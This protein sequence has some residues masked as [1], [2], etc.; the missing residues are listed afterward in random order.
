M[1]ENRCLDEVILKQD[2]CHL[3]DVS[4]KLLEQI[5]LHDG[6]HPRKAVIG[7]NYPLLYLAQRRRGR[8]HFLNDDGDTRL[9][10]DFR[11]QEFRDKVYFEFLC[12]GQRIRPASDLLHKSVEKLL[13]KSQIEAILGCLV[14][15]SKLRAL[16]D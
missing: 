8:A 10:Y 7:L 9:F 4:D 12:V 2:R 16:I 3:N 1:R 5:L 14:V 13:V 15:Q 11:L 6:T